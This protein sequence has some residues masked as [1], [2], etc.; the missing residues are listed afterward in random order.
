LIPQRLIE[1][2]RDGQALSEEQMSHLLTGYHEGKIPDHQMAAF[3]MA[4]VFNGLDGVELKTMLRSMLESGE[5]LDFADVSAHVVDKHSTGGVGDKT[6]LI[7]APL[8]ASLGAIVPMMSGRGLGHTGGTLDKLHAIE[9]FRT[10]LS[11]AEFR[12]VVE[13]VGCAMVGQTEQIAPLDKRLY[14]LRD[15]TG[16]VPSPPLITTSILSKKL[17]EGIGGLVLD[18]KVGS[19]AFIPEHTEALGLARLLVATA[20]A[21]GVRTVARLTAMDRP[22]GRA[23]GNALEVA[24][25]L[26]TLLGRGPVDLR[27]LCIELAVEMLV[28][29]GRYDDPARA[30]RD[31][32]AS[33]DDGRA[34]EVFSRMVVA[35]G[36]KSSDLSKS[37]RFRAAPFV[38]R[39]EA[40]RDGVVTAI[41]PRTLGWGVVE[42]GGGRRALRDEIDPAVGFILDVSLGVSVSAGD[43][44]GRVYARTP[45]G[46]AL[47]RAR[48]E[49][50]TRIA[51]RA[52][53]V[54]P[55]FVDRVSAATLDDR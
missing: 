50:A 51:D 14:A 55:L 1:A 27:A 17:A 26:D 33:L 49:R 37:D 32:E 34:F 9:G 12:G 47:G 23:V 38:E 18:V 42:L 35:Q 54:P 31:A 45:D 2:K 46:A 24:E 19:G 52:V 53:E 5:R 48:L 6:S 3:L 11:L 40:P 29:S 28:I 16:T 43:V 8:I 36:G 44:L 10:D 20:E 30:R 41:D 7:L 39:V 25:A 21:E 13:R 4:V 15:V 22:L